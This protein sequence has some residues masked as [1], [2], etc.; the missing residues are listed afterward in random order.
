MRCGEKFS[1][2][3]AQYEMQSPSSSGDAPLRMLGLFFLLHSLN[4]VVNDANFSHTKKRSS[5][6]GSR[7]TEAT[8][9]LAGWTISRMATILIGLYTNEGVVGHSYLEP[10]LKQSMRY[11]IPAFE[12]LAAAAKGV[13]IVV[14]PA[15]LE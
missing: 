15:A 2:L 6:P 7:P 9:C 11:I 4:E 1:F 12:D 14:I 13:P 3:A 10:Y 8:R 5:A